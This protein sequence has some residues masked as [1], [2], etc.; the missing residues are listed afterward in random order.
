VHHARVGGSHLWKNIGKVGIAGAG[1]VRVILFFYSERTYEDPI[2]KFKSANLE[3]LEKLRDRLAVGL[4]IVGGP[5][6]WI[7]S[8]CE[9]GHVRCGCIARRCGH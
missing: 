8:R 4:G 1:Y 7:L 6:G 5:R 9:V 2:L 3:R